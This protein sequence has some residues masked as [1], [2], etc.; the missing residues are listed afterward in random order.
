M[1]GKVE[2]VV[3]EW[4]WS[5]TCGHTEHCQI[6]GAST[7]AVEDPPYPQA[8]LGALMFTWCVSLERVGCQFRCRPRHLIEI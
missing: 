6:V 4:S 8:G 7:G 3:A 2:A 1:L 5:R